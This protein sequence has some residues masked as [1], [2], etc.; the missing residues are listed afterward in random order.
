MAG[1]RTKHDD[2]DA[3]SSPD[4][5]E[6]ATQPTK[7]PSSKPEELK[8]RPTAYDKLRKELS[9]DELSQT[10]VQ[11][12]LLY[13]I[14]D[15]SERVR[16]LEKF[17]RRAYKAEKRLAVANSKIQDT[18]WVSILEALCLAFGGVLLGFSRESNEEK[19]TWD[20]AFLAI[21]GLLIVAAIFARVYYHRS[22]PIASEEEEEEA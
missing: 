9:E 5:D 22:S 2:D 21:G 1:E 15:Y 13:Q 12:L 17:K 4:D 10:G 8:K 14:D 11:K 20:W 6:A 7:S 16:E 19:V 3:A 18:S